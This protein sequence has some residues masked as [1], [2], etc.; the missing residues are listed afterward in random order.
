MAADQE[1]GQLIA[2]SQGTTPFAGNMALGATRDPGLAERVGHAMGLELRA[3]GVNV[4]YAPVCDVA[5][6]PSAPAL[7]IRAF[8]DDPSLVANLAAASIRGHHAAGVAAVPKHFPGAGEV[9]VDTHHG[10]AIVPGD[11][12]RFDAVELVPFRAA[13][14]ADARL[15]MAG[16]FA[17]PGL[18][19]TDGLPASLSHA[20]I[21][22][23]LRHELGFEGLAI[24]D[25]LD[26][27]AI[28]Q[29][30]L[31]ALEAV[32]A[33]HA[34]L[35]LL[36]CV[37][38]DGRRRI[39]EALVHAWSRQLL[40]A[41]GV[42]SSLDR[43]AALRR[44][45]ATFPQPGLDVVG[46]AAHRAL[47]QELAERSITLVRDTAAILPLRSGDPARVAVVQARPSDLTPADTSSAVA[48]G[49][50]SA[51][52]RLRPDVDEIVVEPRPS[53]AE[54]AAVRN[55]VHGHDLLIVGTFA[56]SMQTEQADLVN[57]LMATGIPTVTVALRTPFDLAAYPAAGTH[58]C[59]YGVLPPSLEAL[60]GA[61]LGR[62]PLRGVLP[63]AIPGLYPGGHGIR[64]HG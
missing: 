20:V 64:T 8:G 10:H 29:G 56:A 25:A 41:A 26:M 40:D 58:L 27:G 51:I 23:L 7:G 37:D 61:L 44:W 14:A 46:S 33:V 62:L 12:S 55:A 52:R 49:L 6:G 1:G 24:S 30:P 54:I 59:T 60:A 42:R 15:I 39:E 16:H 57:A 22:R 35:D 45:L 43:I 34:G 4:N 31:L 17:V 11:R 18:T 48:P 5:T 9:L 63:A 2:L 13:I 38:P 53:P 32:A 28:D 47:A 21:G 36:L 50:A 3:M 19:G